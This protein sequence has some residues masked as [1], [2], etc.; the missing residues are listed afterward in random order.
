MTKN[1]MKKYLPL[2][3]TII[4]A[5][6]LYRMIIFGEIV[7]AND[8]LARHP[9]NEWR[10][11][12]IAENENMPQWYPNLFSGMPSYG[13][14][15]YMTGD[16]TK[17]FR[18]T[19][20]FNLGL[21]VWF[22]LSLGGFGTFFLLKTLGS[23]SNA[24]VL[25]GL[26]TGLTPYGFGLV[27]AGH[28]N[29]IFAM[30][31]VPWVLACF[32]V[33]M[34]KKSLKSICVLSLITALQ[35][36]ANHPQIVYYTWMIIGFYYVWSIGIEYNNKS[37]SLASKLYELGGVLVALFLALIMVS[38][39][40][41]E[42]YTFQKHSNRGAKSVLEK[43]EKT[44]LGTNW[45]YATQWS[46]HPKEVISFVYPYFYGLQNFSTRDLKSAA[47]WGYMPFT[48]STHYLGLIALILASIGALLKKPDK[49]SLFFWIT[50]ILILITGFG[51][52]FPLLYKPFFE[53]FPFFSKFRIPSMIYA[54]L[55]ITISILAARGY[56][57]L[58]SSK[59]EK[60]PFKKAFYFVGGIVAVSFLFLI[61][62]DFMIDFSSSKDGRYNS[63]IQGE[64]RSIRYDLFNKG[65]FLAISVSLCFLGLYYSYVKNKISKSLF[66]FGVI[67]L[68]ILDLGILNNEFI[69]VKPKKNMDRM[70][71]KN[72]I[73]DHLISDKS[74]FRVFPA[75]E[76]TSNKYSY[77]NVESIGGYRPIKLRAYQD[78][79]DA[80]G[81][82]RSHILDML[83][84]KYVLTRKKINNP[85]FIPVE[86]IQGIYENKKVL[87]KAWIIGDLK[88]VESQKESLTETLMTGFNPYSSAVVLKY[89]GD[90]MPAN[91]N[92]QAIIKLKKENTI[93]INCQSETGGLLVVS[94]IYYK[95]G[96]KAF[97][98]GVET[99]IYQTN[100]ILRSVYIP[101]GESEVL[102]EYDNSRWQ[103]T[104]MLSRISLLTVL[105]LIG[106]SILRERKQKSN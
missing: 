92:G 90:N 56:D 27:N 32:L 77:W 15:I 91:A 103:N 82:N 85:N 60:H 19:I 67:G 13:G 25:G 81:F 78:L 4:P 70:F 35:L 20:L 69:N 63:S 45:N 101:A 26:I 24:G 5:L 84:V 65:C 49:I 8:D 94:E 97:V 53:L 11:K 48:Q 95:P 66:N 57:I 36:W 41:N 23:S 18:N 30:A 7:T 51:N 102:F 21:K 58:V 86:E 37:F 9:I 16:P 22:F 3:I 76:I 74:N 6:F 59:G 43:M 105:M 34:K 50:T 64:L 44:S 54:L 62:S 29:K 89:E 14:Y 10:D 1:S 93:E 96:W 104:R 55:P 98:N 31:Y 33:F 47:Y 40:Y 100:H 28:L 52:F 83:N 80:G 99:K 61:V 106:F 71:Q 68:I 87:P 88:I 39:P 73:I 75:D 79:M 46:F 17:L 72:S 2:L 42:V 12:Y 38:D